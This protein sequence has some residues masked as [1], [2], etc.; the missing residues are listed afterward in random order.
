MFDCVVNDWNYIHPN[1]LTSKDFENLTLKY[2]DKS[3][4]EQILDLKMPEGEYIAIPRYYT[5][6]NVSNFKNVKSL[7]TEGQDININLN[8]NFKP[9]NEH[10]V[11]AINSILKN[12]HGIIEAK[13]SFGK[14]YVA[15][16]S[17]TRLKKK[18][19][20]LVHKSALITQWK[21]EF[22]KYTDI[23]EDEISILEGSKYKIN[24]NIKIYIATVQNFA[25][26]LKREN[27]SEVRNE[28]Y[29]ANIGITFM[30]EC[31]VTSAPYVFMQ[32]TR[33]AF[34]KRIYGLS[35]T[36]TRGDIFDNVSKWILGDVIFKDTRITMPV[37][38]SFCPIKSIVPDNQYRY[39]TYGRNSYNLRYHE[40]LSAD[41]TYVTNCVNYIKELIRLNR[42]TLVICPY[43]NLLDSVFLN[44]KL[45]DETRKFKV[46]GTTIEKVQEYKK[47]GEPRK[48]L[49]TKK[50][51]HT[52][53]DVD[54]HDVVFSTLK[55]FDA[56]LSIEWFDTLMF[57]TPPPIKS[58][59][60]IPQVV[61]RLLRDYEGKKFIYILDMYNSEI[62]I[63][64]MR[65]LKRI[66]KYKELKYI[67]AG[68]IN[69]VRE[70]D[71][72]IKVLTSNFN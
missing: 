36:P 46:H 6:E 40:W 70:L 3:G 68:T 44:L 16:D 61:G 33:L 41:Y 25:S 24:D 53:L 20:I 48:R 29:N 1:H 32:G 55:F 30:D 49:S 2:V 63:E 18:A 27:V 66:N 5:P 52:V 21:N 17:I 35:A 22:L 4:L 71:K 7:M 39:L 31:H 60:S 72:K 12:T 58:E 34:S 67:D 45:E 43:K 69:D 26:K 19:L 14:T 50:I 56:G 10:Q 54:K 9:K 38:F 37:Y 8:P 11:S 62:D 28:M 57:L 23:T 47:N 15:I 59:S 42:K 13:T 65:Y 51:D 64:R